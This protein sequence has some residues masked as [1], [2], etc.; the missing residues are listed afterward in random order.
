MHQL[1]RVIAFLANSTEKVSGSLTN[2]K[3]TGDTCAILTCCTQGSIR[4]SVSRRYVL[5]WHWWRR[6]NLYPSPGVPPVQYGVASPQRQQRGGSF[7]PGFSLPESSQS[8][9]QL[10]YGLPCEITRPGGTS[11]RGDPKDRSQREHY[12]RRVDCLRFPGA[13]SCHV[14][15][16]M[17]PR[18][19]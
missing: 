11:E 5:L 4:P 15:L 18:Y 7:L 12:V 17:A 14:L 6:S 13:Q 10:T 3:T 19:A 16:M 1:T 2:R 8:Q 9:T